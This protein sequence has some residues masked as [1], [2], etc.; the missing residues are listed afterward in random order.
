M[1]EDIIPAI[2]KRTKT[3]LCPKNEGC[4]AREFSTLQDKTLLGRVIQKVSKGKSNQINR[5]AYSVFKEITVGMN[6]QNERV[7]KMK[8]Y[9]G[10]S[11]INTATNKYIKWHIIFSIGEMLKE[12]IC[13][14]I[15]RMN[16]EKSSSCETY[17][18]MYTKHSKPL[19]VRVFRSG[20]CNIICIHRQI[21]RVSRRNRG[22]RR[23]IYKCKL[24]RNNQDYHGI[25]IL[26]KG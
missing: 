22:K 7:F 1:L 6:W 10:K 18:P 11:I 13:L 12:Q 17:F 9:N 16:I 4:K 15:H 3:K 21:I 20:C 23:N 25:W 8:I 5:M 19:S 24:N 14:Y 2:H 26:D